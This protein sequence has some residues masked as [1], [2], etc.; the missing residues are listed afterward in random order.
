[1]RQG[2]VWP[3]LV[4]VEKRDV[5]QRERQALVEWEGEIVGWSRGANRRQGEEEGLHGNRVI[6]GETAIGRVGKH[7]VEVPPVLVDTLMERSHE[8][9]VAPGADAGLLVRRDIGRIDRP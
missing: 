3:E 7:G 5:P 6:A 9:V 4:L 2:W 1:M 8:I